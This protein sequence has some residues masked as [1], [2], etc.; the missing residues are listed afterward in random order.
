MR[1]NAVFTRTNVLLCSDYDSNAH[2]LNVSNLPNLPHSEVFYL[3]IDWGLASQSNYGYKRRRRVGLGLIVPIWRLF[4]ARRHLHA[5][6]TLQRLLRKKVRVSNVYLPNLASVHGLDSNPQPWAQQ[7]NALPTHLPRP[8]SAVLV[9]LMACTESRDRC[10]GWRASWRTQRTI[11]GVWMQPL[12]LLSSP[13]GEVDGRL[14]G[15]SVAPPC[16]A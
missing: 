1:W 11:V 7:A 9:Q 8:V 4:S 14:P 3:G 16:D 15:K 6:P 12:A 2:M 13:L 10:I 5:L